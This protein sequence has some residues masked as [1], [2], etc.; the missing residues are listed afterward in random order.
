[1]HVFTFDDEFFPYMAKYRDWDT[2]EEKRFKAW[3]GHGSPMLQMIDGAEVYDHMAL[4]M[5]DCLN[6]ELGEMHR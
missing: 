4:M 5:T 6:M 2:G 1:M 3:A